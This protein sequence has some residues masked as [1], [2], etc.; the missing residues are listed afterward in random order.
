[1][2]GA[3]QE[4]VRRANRRLPGRRLPLRVEQI[5]KW[6]DTAGWAHGLASSGRP[7]HGVID[8]MSPLNFLPSS[9]GVST[10]RVC[11]GLAAV[12]VLLVHCG[13][14]GCARQRPQDSVAGGFSRPPARNQPVAAAE[15]DE[16]EP[17]AAEPVAAEPVAAEPVA[18]EPV[19]AE[20]G[21]EPEAAPTVADAPL[22]PAV[23][24]QRAPQARPR[25]ADGGVVAGRSGDAGE[26]GR[27]AAGEAAGA[28]RAKAAGAAVL[29]GRPR[30]PPPLTAAEAATSAG[31]LL[32][33]ARAAIRRGDPATASEKALAAYEY[34]VPH[35]ATNAACRGLAGEAERVIDAVGSRRGPAESLPTR[36]E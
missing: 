20:P 33:E 34:L 16:A 8:P 21:R 25:D 36:F 29:P 5:P 26:G 1:V 6:G 28:E 14:S 11:C 27:P 31:Q 23:D 4:V 17:V 19:V 24:S 9:P 2:E 3:G 7:V 35:V 12:L 10:R 15:P 30:Q 13:C 22:E 32:D 18:A